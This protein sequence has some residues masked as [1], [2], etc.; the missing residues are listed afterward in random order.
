[1]GS[2]EVEAIM[3]D[4]HRGS[5]YWSKERYRIIPQRLTAFSVQYLLV[6]SF[7]NEIVSTHALMS[8]AMAERDRLDPMQRRP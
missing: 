5:I 4:I 8:A 3:A 1:M 2:A 6:D 7:E